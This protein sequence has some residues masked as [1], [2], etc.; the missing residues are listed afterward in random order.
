MK[1][2]ILLKCIYDQK[3]IPQI[4]PTSFFKIL[5]NE[6]LKYRDLSI[7]DPELTHNLDKIICTDVNEMNLSFDNVDEMD[8]RKVDNNNKYEFKKK[9]ITFELFEKQKDQ[10]NSIKKGKI[11]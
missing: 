5:T 6:K 7:Y 3:I 2:F 1:G 8:E 9:M 4:F 11:N 10:L